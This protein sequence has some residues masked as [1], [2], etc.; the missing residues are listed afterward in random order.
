MLP[1]AKLPTQWKVW[2]QS[3]LGAE[4]QP[5]SLPPPGEAALRLCA[6]TAG[7]PPQARGAQLEGFGPLGSCE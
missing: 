6:E 5:P 1:T 7:A 2:C 3:P 4:A